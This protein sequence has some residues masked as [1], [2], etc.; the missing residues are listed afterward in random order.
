MIELLLGAGG[1]DRSRSR[2]TSRCAALHWL[3]LVGAT[4]E[5][6]QVVGSRHG[7]AE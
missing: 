3:N 2:E 6:M 1:G 5:F 4:S 7:S